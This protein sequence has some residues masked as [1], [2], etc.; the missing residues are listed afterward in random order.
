MLQ[1]SNLRRKLSSNRFD[2]HPSQLPPMTNG[3]MV[4]FAPLELESDHLLVFELFNHFTHHLCPGNNW[5]A[6]RDGRSVCQ[7]Y[8]V[9]K[10]DFFTMGACEF[11][12][13]NG[14]PGGHP[15]LLTSR[16]NNRV[17][18][19]QCPIGKAQKLP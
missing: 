13:R 16:T 1:N 14:L 12:N 10:R 3:P 15:I 19:V 6:S 5:I 7:Q 11:I 8:N 18:H 2:L 17:R 9:S 4:P